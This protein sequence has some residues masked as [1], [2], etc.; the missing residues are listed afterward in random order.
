M[1]R[2]KL[3]VLA[4]K[5]RA[6]RCAALLYLLNPLTI[7]T[8]ERRNAYLD[9]TIVVPSKTALSH[10]ESGFHIESALGSPF[11]IESPAGPEC[12]IHFPPDWASVAS[13]KRF[14]QNLDRGPACRRP[15]SAPAKRAMGGFTV[16]AA[17]CLD[18]AAF[19]RMVISIASGGHW[20]SRRG[21]SLRLRY[22][23]LS[24]SRYATRG[25]A[26]PLGVYMWPRGTAWRLLNCSSW[27]FLSN[28]MFALAVVGCLRRTAVRV[29]QNRPIQEPLTKRG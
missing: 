17:A 24:V 28:L 25:A 20:I 8:S 22:R 16:R 4:D 10:N 19:P 5:K 14:V 2:V 29:A 1:P 23:G 9:L 21:R 18:S 26:F 6:A 3:A 7:S 15:P 27:G 11:H 12:H 13:S